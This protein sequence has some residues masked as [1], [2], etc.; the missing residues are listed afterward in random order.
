MWL[1]DANTWRLISDNL[2]TKNYRNR[3]ILRSFGDKNVLRSLGNLLATNWRTWRSIG[4]FG[5]IWQ[6]FREQMANEAIIARIIGKW[7]TKLFPNTPNL[8][9][10]FR[11]IPNLIAFF[12]TCN[13]V[14]IWGNSNCLGM[15]YHAVKSQIRRTPASAP[16]DHVLENTSL[17]SLHWFSVGLPSATLAQHW[18]NAESIYV[19]FWECALLPLSPFPTHTNLYPMLFQY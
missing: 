5:T 11:S 3:R 16:K 12:L 2:V 9:Q 18:T 6:L 19:I 10:T 8:W 13:L 7:V 17:L 14:N 15:F 1:Q 4:E